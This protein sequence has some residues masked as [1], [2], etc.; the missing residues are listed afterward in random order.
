MLRDRHTCMCRPRK[1]GIDFSI[2][3]DLLKND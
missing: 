3:H 2:I 1:T